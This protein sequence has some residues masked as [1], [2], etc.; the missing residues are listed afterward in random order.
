MA[1]DTYYFSHD[2]NARNDKKISALVRDF[3]SSGYG[4]FWATCE[5]MHEEG[6]ML[7][8]DELTVDAIARD[9]NETPELVKEVIGMCIEKYKLFIKDDILLK[10]SRVHRNLETKNEKKSVKAEA[11]RL[12]GIKSGESRRNKEL[13]K[14]NEAVLQDA[15]SIEPNES[16]VKEIKGNESKEITAPEYWFLRY[17]HSTYEIYKGAFNGQSTTEDYFKQW[18]EFIDFIYEK[19]YE[20]LF[21]CKFLS[22]HSF[23]ELVKKK[24]FVKPI[25]DDVLHK[26]LS[27]G[28]KP[29]HDL[30]FRIPEFMGYLKEVPKEI[31]KKNINNWM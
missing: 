6:G 16:K 7:E 31:D 24:K 26:I 18:K 19:K 14:Q 5:M 17:Y 8:F 1:K 29:E 9:I 22:P 20:S 2:Y 12:G 25:W 27:T 10:S 15:S 21:D 11:G 28:I 4:I 13:T 3:K 23:A 30:F